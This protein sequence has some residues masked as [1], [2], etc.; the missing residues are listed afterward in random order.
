MTLFEDIMVKIAEMM[1]NMKRKQL[2][3]PNIK[4]DEEEYM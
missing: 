1:L 3:N 2:T 4:I